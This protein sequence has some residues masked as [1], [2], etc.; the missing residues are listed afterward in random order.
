MGEAIHH[1]GSCRLGLDSKMLAKILNMSTG[2]CWSSDTYNPYPGVFEGVPSSNNYQGGFGSQLMAKV[3][4]SQ[5]F[6]YLFIR[7]V[8]IRKSDGDLPKNK[9][10]I[11][12]KPG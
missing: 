8:S 4:I 2:R 11:I 5:V 10:N 6:I 9:N 7:S 1:F 3:C 12:R